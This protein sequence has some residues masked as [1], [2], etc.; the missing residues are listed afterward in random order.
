VTTSTDESTASEQ[1]AL[2]DPDRTVP[3]DRETT[4]VWDLGEDPDGG[5]RQAVRKINH[6]KK[7]RGGEFSATLL[8]QTEEETEFGVEQRM[9]SVLDWKCITTEAVARYSSARLEQFAEGALERLG[10]VYGQDSDEARS[11]RGYFQVLS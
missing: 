6:H 11:V 5:T 1:D 3:G 7:S 4:F 2:R 10:T 9:G 8:N